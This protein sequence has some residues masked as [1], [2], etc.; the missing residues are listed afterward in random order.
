MHTKLPQELKELIYQYLYIEDAPIPVGSYHFTTYIPE[1]LR[2]EHN[3]PVQ[4]EP[5]IVI[6][7]GAVRQDHSVERD[8]NI[9]YPDNWLL[10]PAFLGY[11][12]AKDASRYYYK[13]NSFSVCTLE[14]VLLD[15]LF[16]DP[17]QNFLGE[18]TGQEEVQPLNLL[19]INHIRNL[20]IRVKYEHYTTYLTFYDNLRDGEKNL[21]GN[22]FG[23]LR[24]LASRI[25]P[26]AASQLK[27][28]FCM[29]T[30]YKS[31]GFKEERAHINLLEAVRVPV[32]MFKYDLHADITVTHYDEYISP[33]PKNITGLFKL[34]EN[35]WQYVSHQTLSLSLN[36]ALAT[37]LSCK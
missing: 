7:E 13:A 10:N 27:V 8:E 25:R 26:A 5:F 6:P 11:T 35:Q 29:M 16:Q 18:Q 20:Q 12:V 36:H 24:N 3:P 31:T 34:S 37:I 2:S 21:I 15:F 33:F 1:P 19:P 32:Y 28:E 14:N 30:T 23:T 4:S 17:I 9:I 22:I